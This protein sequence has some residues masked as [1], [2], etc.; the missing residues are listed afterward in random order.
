V[1]R[2]KRHRTLKAHGPASSVFPFLPLPSSRQQH[3]RGPCIRDLPTKP[4]QGAPD[5]RRPDP[6]RSER[7]Q[8]AQV[9]SPSTMLRVAGRRL[10]S[11]LAWRPAAAGTRGP[12]AGTLPGR[13][14]DDTRDRRAR[15]AIDSPFFAAA[16]GMCCGRSSHPRSARFGRDAILSLLLGFRSSRYLRLFDPWYLISVWSGFAYVLLGCS[17]ICV[18]SASI[19][20]VISDRSLELPGYDRWALVLAVHSFSVKQFPFLFLVMSVGTECYM[21]W[22]NMAFGLLGLNCAT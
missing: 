14:D 21:E 13:D 17:L 7:P 8:P 5:P 19:L 22:K 2:P 12:F 18:S 10:S 20:D 15:F 6:A 9:S 3:A 4:E 1:K 11:A 16:R